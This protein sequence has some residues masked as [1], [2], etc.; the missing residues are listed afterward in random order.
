M[1]IR[2][3]LLPNVAIQP[4]RTEPEALPYVRSYL[5]MRLAIACL[6][7]AVPLVLVFVEPLLFE[8]QPSPRGSLS[9]YYYSG[10]REF[11]VGALFAIGFFLITYKIIERS[12]ENLASFFAGIA[13]IV[14][15]LFPTG[16]PGS[17]YPPTPIQDL[18]SEGVVQ[19]IHYG[20]AVVFISLLAAGPAGTGST[21]RT[22]RSSSSRSVWP[23]CT[24]RPDGRTTAC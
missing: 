15:A 21:S 18:L 24:R 16:R 5:V 6:G 2:E 1:A 4:R 10:M 7:I 11:F 3:F 17:G 22:P 20:A 9:A 12:W 19:W 8:G 23:R 13:V 14:V